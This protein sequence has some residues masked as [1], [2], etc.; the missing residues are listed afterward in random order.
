MTPSTL[1][2]LA[3]ETARK[4]RREWLDPVAAAP[5]EWIPVNIAAWEAGLASLIESALKRAAMA[6]E[7]AA[8]FQGYP[9]ELVHACCEYM[10]Q[11]DSTRLFRVVIS[12]V[13]A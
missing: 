1:R 3:E 2:A 7:G 10:A 4:Y 8:M 12:E 11:H 13:K 5:R 6:E 9:E